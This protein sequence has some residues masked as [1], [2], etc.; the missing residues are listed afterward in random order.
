MIKEKLAVVNAQD[1]IIEIRDRDEVHRLTLRHRAVH[2]LIFN[3]KQKLFLQKRSHQ[4]DINAGLWDSSAAGHVDAG[5]DYDHCVI[6]EVSEELGIQLHQQPEFLFKLSPCYDNGMEFIHVY[7]SPHNG[8]F[9]LCTEE[10]EQGQW[11][12]IPEI[13]ELVSENALHLTSTFKS[14]WK[15]F[16]TLSKTY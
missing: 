10:I 14:I 7:R 11:F 5:E 8:P 12:S 2:I 15:S 6:R 3:Q 13:S 16:I 4:K 1:K 9:T